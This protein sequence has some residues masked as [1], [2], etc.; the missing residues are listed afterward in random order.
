ML[1]QVISVIGAI[2]MLGAYAALQTGVLG[3]DDRLFHVLNFAGGVL[4]AWVAI[5]DR[6]LGFILLEGTWALLSLPGML[7]RAPRPPAAT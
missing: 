7:R 2:L 1:L 6:R 5:A 4:L 3:R